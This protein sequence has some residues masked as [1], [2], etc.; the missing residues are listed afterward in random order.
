MRYIL[1]GV[2]LVLGGC[3]QYGYAPQYRPPLVLQPYQPP[4]MIPM[5]PARQ[6]FTCTTYGHVTNCF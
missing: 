5:A 1:I 2:V 3:A 4:P 6:A